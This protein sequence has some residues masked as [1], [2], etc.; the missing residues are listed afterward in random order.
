MSNNTIREE[1]K[2]LILHAAHII[3]NRYGIA[4]RYYEYWYVV[5]DRRS[6][7][8]KKFGELI[9]TKEP[10]YSDLNTHYKI[11]FLLDNGTYWSLLIDK[12]RIND[13]SENEMTVV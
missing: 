1:T 9:K 2:D 8:L 11:S 10:L 4:N 5:E 3:S 6:G 12:V 7:D 13:I